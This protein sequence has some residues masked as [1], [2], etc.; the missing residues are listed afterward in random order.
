MLSITSTLAAGTA[1][2]NYHQTITVN[3]GIAPTITI[4]QFNA[5]G[6]GLKASVRTINPAQNMPT[7]TINGTPTAAGTATFTVHVTDSAGFT[8]S[9]T[10]QIIINAAPTIGNLTQKQWTVS[11]SGFSG[12]M[13]ISGGTGTFHITHAAGLPT[14][15][16]ATL[17][18]NT[19]KFTG[20]PSVANT[21]ASGSITITD[22]AGA[23]VTKT[24]QITVNPPLQITTITLPAWTIGAAY[25][26]T[27]HTTGGTS[28]VTF[29]IASG[30]LPTGLKLNSNGQITGVSKVKGSVAI[31]IIATDACGATATKKYTF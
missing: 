5:G 10:Y 30:T 11:K 18:G 21:Y 20:T 6:T 7:I 8:L 3:G 9:K 31:T 4:S 13:T 24:F 22:A 29:A 19:I 12:I 25:T 2:V 26:A 15:L 14:G 17:S 23:S 16:T 1:G 28:S 27:V